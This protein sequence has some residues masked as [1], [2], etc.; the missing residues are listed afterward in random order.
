MAAPSLEINIKPPVAQMGGA[1]TLPSP[2]LTPTRDT[3]PA[4]GISSYANSAVDQTRESTREKWNRRIREGGCHFSLF[5]AGW[6]DA[7]SGPLI[8]YIQA[9]Y[10]ISYTVV[11]MLFIGQMAGFLA[12]GF[13]NAWL[14]DRFGLGK[15][16]V[17]GACLQATA[18]ALLIPAFPFP[19]FPPIYAL[20]GIG[21]ALQDAQ[22]NVYV[23]QL[24]GAETK[25][26]YLHGAYGLGAAVCPLAATAFASSGILFARFYSI[27]LGIAVVNIGILLYAFRFSY[28]V[29]DSEPLKKTIEAPGLPP[30]RLQAQGDDIELA[31]R[32]DSTAATSFVDKQPGIAEAEQASVQLS[33]LDTALPVK[34][35]KKSWKNNVLYLTLWNRT[36]IFLSLFTFLYVGSEV[37]MG[38]WIVTYMIEDRGGGSDAGYV[39]SGFWFGLML[40]R[41]LLNPLNQ[42]V[43]EQR[44]IYV[45]TTI[46]LG[47]EFAIWFADSLVGNAVVVGIIGVLMGPS[48][49]ILIS[50]GTKIWPR[51]LHASSIAFVAAFGQTG[52]AVFPFITGALAQKFNPVV[53]QPIMICLFVGQMVTWACVPRIS[54][55]KE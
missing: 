3:S 41:L 4:P 38:G 15:V 52:S 21:L 39:A 18:Y 30:A 31:E 24:P 47:L 45:Y 12:S 8:P 37:A 28:R 22:A 44:V 36:T 35:E 20:G 11:S 46:A 13:V 43:G 16:I 48:Y 53:L 26:G 17:L 6:G 29:D 23:A 54:K 2:P 7:S 34:K 55:R 5:I 51:R 10:N 32:R 42:W 49:P 9:H 50:V 14:T 25:L 27:S 1:S 40:G 19:A 33:Q